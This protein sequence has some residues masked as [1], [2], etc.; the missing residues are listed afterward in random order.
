MRSSISI[1]T[2]IPSLGFLLPS[3][4]SSL[5]HLPLV[6]MRAFSNNFDVPHFS[7]LENSIHKIN[8]IYGP[9]KLEKK[10]NKLIN[11]INK[12]IDKRN[13]K[14]NKIKTIIKTK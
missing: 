7:V 2:W 6:S 13:N 10:I 11:K 14:R 1:N 5:L 3:M 8:K 4:Y 9:N 12:K